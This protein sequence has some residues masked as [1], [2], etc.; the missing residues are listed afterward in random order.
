MVPL[1]DILHVDKKSAKWLTNGT[2]EIWEE[3]MNTETLKCE[4]FEN[5]IHVQ[6]EH[7]GKV[8]SHS[9]HKIFSIQPTEKI[10]VTVF[11][12]RD[13]G[14]KMAYPNPLTDIDDEISLEISA[15]AA[16]RFL[17][18]MFFLLADGTIL[19]TRVTSSQEESFQLFQ[20]MT[21]GHKKQISLP[22]GYRSFNMKTSDGENLLL[23]NFEG[24]LDTVNWSGSDTPKTIATS[25]RS[26]QLVGNAVV[27]LTKAG[28]LKLLCLKFKEQTAEY[29][30]VDMETEAAQHFVAVP[31]LQQMWILSKNDQ[32]IKY[33][34]PS[35]PSDSN[36]TIRA[37][38]N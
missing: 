33:G 27:V 19:R 16:C 20:T 24:D 37:N 11:V 9:E 10:N 38:A 1:E 2:P 5:S 36:N 18:E 4:R 29:F 8:S 15:V 31:A 13:C 32:I 34:M 22:K 7:M 12:L 30:T 14:I 28:K 3:R 26:F 35:L 23:K 6:Y 25:V 21:A 17:Q